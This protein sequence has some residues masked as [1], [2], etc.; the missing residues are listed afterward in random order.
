MGG[1]EFLSI[2]FLVETS[3]S[4]IEVKH[5]GV[6]VRPSRGLAILAAMVEADSLREFFANT[7]HKQLEVSNIQRVIIRKVIVVIS[8][9][10]ETVLIME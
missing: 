1:I 8:K 4:E 2:G 9:S 6:I 3:I 5:N 7:F 10:N